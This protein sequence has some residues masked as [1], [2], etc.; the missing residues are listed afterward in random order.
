MN[1]E[2]VAIQRRVGATPDGLWGPATARAITTALD[3][4][5]VPPAD[6]ITAL[7]IE[8]LR[9]EEGTV[10]SAYQD[11]LGYWTLGTGRL[12]DKRKG[13]GITQ[14]END[15]LLGND[16][17]KVRAQLAIDEDTAAAW[18][19]VKDDPVRAVAL[20]SL[21]FQ[22]GVGLP[23]KDDAGLSGFDGTLAL[24]AAGNFA[25][26]AENALKS[27]WAKQTPARAKRVTNMLRT[28]QMS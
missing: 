14:A 24:I 3:A 11:H 8:H 13:G 5:S 27:L 15:L 22:M 25:G 28:G 1:P 17:A 20:I 19:K 9:R 2:L 4:T 6:R 12:I 21:G 16:I 23:S 10:L 7:A 18:A 26:A